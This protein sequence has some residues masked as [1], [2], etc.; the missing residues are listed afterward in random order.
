MTYAP[1]VC[2][3]NSSAKSVLQDISDQTVLPLETLVGMS[4]KCEPWQ[5]PENLSLVYSNVFT[6]E[7][8]FGYYK[9]NVLVDR[10]QAEWVGFFNQDD[11]HHPRFWELML[12]WAEDFKAD[13]VWCSWNDRPTCKWQPCDSTLGNFIVKRETFLKLGGF[14]EPPKH[15][16]LLSPSHPNIS[17]ILD[18]NHGFRD[19]VFID[20]AIKAGTPTV[21]CPFMLFYHNVPR[22]AEQ[23]VTDWGKDAPSHSTY[24][25][26]VMTTDYQLRRANEVLGSA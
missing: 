16:I 19:A 26:M 4:G 17:F 25:R 24:E 13:I 3:H 18:D 1:I 22:L 8:D 15:G 6:Q 12:K 23:A 9:R 11:S 21:N 20:N 5:P 10:T 2:I 7:G 14:P